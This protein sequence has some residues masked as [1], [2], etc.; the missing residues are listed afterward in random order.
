MLAIPREIYWRGFYGEF[1]PLGSKKVKFI[2][3]E[4]HKKKSRNFVALL[5][6]ALIY[7][8]LIECDLCAKNKYNK[9]QA[10]AY[11]IRDISGCWNWA[12]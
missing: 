3:E 6:S 8:S 10:S 1:V 2:S 11:L 4:K 12:E 7:A 9:H 5:D